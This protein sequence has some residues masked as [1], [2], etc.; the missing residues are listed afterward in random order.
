MPELPEVET[1]IR[2]LRP[3]LTGKILSHPTI[4]VDRC[5]KGNL[6]EY[7]EEI[8]GRK[9]LSVTRKGKCILLNLDNDHTILFHLRMEGKLFVVEK[10]NYDTKHLSLIIPFEDSTNALAFYDTRKFGISMY[11]PMDDKEALKNIGPDPFEVESSYEI[12]R[13]YHKSHKTIKEL[14]LCQNI[15]S[16]IGNIYANEILFD[17]KISPFLKGCELKKKQCEDILFSAR[18][19]LQSAIKSNGSTIRSYHAKEGMDGSFQGFLK[20]YG[21]KGKPCPNCSTLI[22]KTFLS[23][24]GCEYCPNCQHTGITIAITG[25]IASGKS[26]VTSYFGKLGFV[27]FSADDYVHE[28]Y[29]DEEFLM[30][31]KKKFPFLF[32]PALDKK[33][34]TT[35]LQSDKK[36]KKEY[37]GLIYTK[38]RQGIEE[39]I[40]QNNGK[41]KALEIPVLF[42][43]HMQS[44][45]NILIGV[46]TTKQRE[47]LLERGDDPSKAL[48]NS[49][50]SYDRHHDELTYIL[51]TDS[52]KKELFRQVKSLAEKLLH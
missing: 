10:K 1:V 25:K 34:I 2:V 12:Y 31:L 17:C 38:V 49:M 33:V 20:V 26:L 35:Y 16:G 14:L 30:Q 19:I 37:L 7:Q 29:S 18:K 50:N 15:L 48:F 28:L 24:R 32:T 13:Q 11:F 47:H 52:T 4:F 46:E 40:L 43:A 45:F 22:E 51:H 6:S 44:M 23:E 42:D 9:V 36:F 41:N 27:T 39:F 21:K 3:E 5:I 8:T